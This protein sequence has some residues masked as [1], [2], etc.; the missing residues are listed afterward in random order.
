MR[1]LTAALFALTWFSFPAGATAES[2]DAAAD[3]T[4]SASADARSAAAPLA[5]SA[6]EIGQLESQFVPELRQT[7]VY[8]R[9]VDPVSETASVDV[10]DD[11]GNVVASLPIDL[12]RG[13]G[14]LVWDG[15]QA[16]GE[17]VPSGLY[18]ARLSRAD[19]LLTGEIVR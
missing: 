1:Q 10:V 16:D 7:F 14:L 11:S 9:L 12:D 4:A 18:T 15:T 8:V 2:A 13:A 6:P 5:V 19:A 17:L 3:T